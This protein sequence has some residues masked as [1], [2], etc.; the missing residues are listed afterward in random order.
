MEVL[1]IH[2]GPSLLRPTLLPPPHSTLASRDRAGVQVGRA[3]WAEDT[4]YFNPKWFDPVLNVKKNTHL[5]D[6]DKALALN[7]QH[8]TIYF[9]Q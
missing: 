9:V 2:R 8:C 5:H 6:F 4:N 1:A 7:R 3:V